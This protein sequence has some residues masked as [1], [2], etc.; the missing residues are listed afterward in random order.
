[1]TL[2]GHFFLSRTNRKTYILDF[3]DFEIAVNFHSEYCS[4]S[5]SC[6][7]MLNSLGLHELYSPWNS[8]GQNSGVVSLSLLQGI[9][10]TQGSNPDLPHCRQ[11]LYCL[12]HQGSPKKYWKSLSGVV[13][14]S[15]LEA[16]WKIT[17][18]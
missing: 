15:D 6:S 9:F 14:W 8:P 17:L 2:K 11:I 10:P 1:M 5:E 18:E 13:I 7:V 3:I 4:G 12:S 16:A